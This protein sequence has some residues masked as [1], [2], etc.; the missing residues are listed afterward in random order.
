MIYLFKILLLLIS[1]NI[2]SFI[3][4][5]DYVSRDDY[6][7]IFAK[8]DSFLIEFTISSQ[9]R[10]ISQDTLSFDMVKR[11]QSMF[12]SGVL[13]PDLINPTIRDK[14][15]PI[16][17]SRVVM[18][19]LKDYINETSLN[20]TK[21]LFMKVRAINASFDSILDGKANIVMERKQWGEWRRRWR[22]E[23]VDTISLQIS[24]LK[25]RGLITGIDVLGFGYVLTDFKS[26]QDL[27]IRKSRIPDLAQIRRNWERENIRVGLLR[28]FRVKDVKTVVAD[29]IDDSSPCCPIPYVLTGTLDY[30]S[31]SPDNKK[32][33]FI[34]EPEVI[35]YSDR[36]GT[37]SYV[38]PDLQAETFR[39]LAYLQP[40]YVVDTCGEFLH[41]IEYKY[42]A[43]V[44]SNGR[45]KTCLQDFGW[46]RR[47]KVLEGCE[48]M[49]EEGTRVPLTLAGTTNA[50]MSKYEANSPA[51]RRYYQNPSLSDEREDAPPETTR[52]YVYKKNGTSVLLG[53]KPS[54]N[55]REVSRVII[56]W[57]R[58][59]DLLKGLSDE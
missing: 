16:M 55:A 36:F 47:S 38:K 35:V 21:G 2:P 5:Q 1:L 20:Y 26:I 58:L 27:A 57:I 7:Q 12:A 37:S 28:R 10:E 18:K 48:C 49:F 53:T 30:W 31:S 29:S 56:G 32:Y 8:L 59:T 51:R 50:G 11:Y 41:I 25:T 4:G 14:E 45:V 9:F 13:H 17:P 43:T 39:E 46:I 19:T 34:P 52:L 42:G 40:F 44:R 24:E 23:L 15:E 6:K 3:Q 33:A 22:L 54:C